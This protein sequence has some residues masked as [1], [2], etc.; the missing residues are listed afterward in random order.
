MA[1]LTLALLTPHSVA[2]VTTNSSSEMFPVAPGTVSDAELA[3]LIRALH[4]VWKAELAAT[5]SRKY[6]MDRWGSWTAED[7]VS[8][9]SFTYLDGDSAAYYRRNWT[10][11]YRQDDRRASAERAFRQAMEM[12]DEF[13][14]SLL[15]HA[16][17]RESIS[18]DQK[19]TAEGLLVAGTPTIGC[20]D[21]CTP[22]SFFRLL[23]SV[24]GGYVFSNR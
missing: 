12:E 4:P 8:A 24:L 13:A 2:D 16:A 18:M 10:D 14:G 15:Q 17:I 21:D 9:F 1:R 11:D 3:G 19:A 22:I 20:D 23:H 7:M 5:P 6:E